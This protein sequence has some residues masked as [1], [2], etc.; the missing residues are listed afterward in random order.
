MAN[1]VTNSAQ[2]PVGA[3]EWEGFCGNGWSTLWLTLAVASPSAPPEGGAATARSASTTRV[4]TAVATDDSDRERSVY[5]VRQLRPV[6]K[7]S[8]QLRSGGIL[9]GCWPAASRSGGG[10]I[11]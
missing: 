2:P 1:L 3:Q 9:R 8:G 7:L 4:T 10:R 5:R 11:L 6:A